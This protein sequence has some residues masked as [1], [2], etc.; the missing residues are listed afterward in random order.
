MHTASNGIPDGSLF[1]CNDTSGVYNVNVQLALTDGTNQG[2][3]FHV[4]EVRLYKNATSTTGRGDLVRTYFIGS[5][6]ARMLNGTNVCMYGGSIQIT[7]EQNDQFEILSSRK[8]AQ[9]SNALDLNEGAE[10]TRLIIDRVVI[11]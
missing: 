5:G 4:E 11:S 10:A 2:R 7:M 6:Y 1:T 8:S 9:N 3:S